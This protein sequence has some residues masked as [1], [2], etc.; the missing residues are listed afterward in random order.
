[1]VEVGL[2]DVRWML[3]AGRDH[4]DPRRHRYE[5]GML[6]RPRTTARRGPRGRG[7]RVARLLA[8]TETRLAELSAG[9]GPALAGT[10]GGR[11]RQAASGC[12]RCWCSSAPDGDG[13]ERLVRRGRPSSCCTWRRSCTTT[14]STARRLRRGRPTVFCELRPAAATATGDLLFSRAFAELARTARRR[15]G[16]VGGVVGARARRADAARRRLDD[17]VKPERYLERCELK[18]ASLFEASCRLGALFGGRRRNGGGAGRASARA[19]AWRS[20]SSTTCSTWPARGADRQDARHGPARRHGDAA[21]DPRAPSA[22]P[23]WRSSTCGQ[24]GA[25]RGGL[26]PDR[27]HRRARGRA[28]EHALEHV[29]EAKHAPWTGLGPARRAA[30][31]KTA[32][33]WSTDGVVERLLLAQAREL[34]VFGRMA[35]RSSASTKRSMSSAMLAGIRRL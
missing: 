24:A 18:T 33:S 23:C 7:R 27:R 3:T 14:C 28:R 26:R 13:D 19:S 8:R 29:A 32:A 12:A 16:A 9:H 2:R 15:A 10:R 17:D 4:R 31:D 34:E 25:G 22:T 30:A 1:M 6:S 20:R 11:S 35:R 5:A 21:A